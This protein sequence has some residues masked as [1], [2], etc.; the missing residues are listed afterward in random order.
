MKSTK[1][2]FRKFKITEIL[3]VQHNIIE[4]IEE[5]RLR[6]CH[7][8]KRIRSYRIPTNK[9]VYFGNSGWVKLEEAWSGKLTEEDAKDRKLWMN[10]F[11][12]NGG[13]LGGTH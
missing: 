6:W 7:H 11:F 10:E 3:N 13:Y 1:Y 2:K 12:G 8:L 9:R 5:R 4:V